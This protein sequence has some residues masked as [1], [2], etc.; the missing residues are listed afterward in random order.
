MK[1]QIAIEYL[2]IIALVLAAISLAAAY[3]WQQNEISTRVQQATVAVNTIAAA[4]DNLYA[5]GPGAKTTINVF[6]PPG[7]VSSLSSVSDNTIVLKVYTPAGYT[8]VPIAT[9]ANVSGSLPEGYGLRVL[10]LETI[11][12]YVNISG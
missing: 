12:G 8:D 3:I 6:F 9:K 1:A 5:Q 10:T 11:N 4:A 7:Y 2:A